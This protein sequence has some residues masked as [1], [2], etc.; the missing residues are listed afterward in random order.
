MTKDPTIGTTDN[1]HLLV[2]LLST[3]LSEIEEEYKSA[4]EPA[5]TAAL[6]KAHT[7]T[8]GAQFHLVKVLQHRQS[9]TG[10]GPGA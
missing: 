6:M 1:M 4:T 9:K 8:G 7:A 5:E 2:T 3:V 10:Q